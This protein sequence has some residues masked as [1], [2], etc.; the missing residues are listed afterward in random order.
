MSKQREKDGVLCESKKV[1]HSDVKEHFK[2]GNM[3][4]LKMFM[5]CSCNLM[6]Y[7]ELLFEVQ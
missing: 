1:R 7:Y 3:P 6:A 5:L 4:R 2:N